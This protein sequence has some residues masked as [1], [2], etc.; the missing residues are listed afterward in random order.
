LLKQRVLSLLKITYGVCGG[1]GCLPITYSN[2]N[3][4][5]H[6]VCKPFGCSDEI[7]SSY[8]L[9]GIGLGARNIL[10]Y[11]CRVNWLFSHAYVSMI[12]LAPE[13]ETNE[14]DD[15]H[16][17]YWF[18]VFTYFSPA[19]LVY[20]G[21]W[22]LFGVFPTPLTNFLDKPRIQLKLQKKLKST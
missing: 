12:G 10:C 11:C 4:Y 17:P 14:D 22:W 18:L 19:G 7:A 13:Q 8:I 15:V 1:I 6:E 2:A 16:D 3:L 5:C 9:W 20:T 21:S